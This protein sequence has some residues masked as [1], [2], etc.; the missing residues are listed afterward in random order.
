MPYGNGMG[1]KGLGPMSGKAM[2]SCA[3]YS[4]ESTEFA[5][6]MGRGRG[7]GRGFRSRGFGIGRMIGNRNFGAR[8][9]FGRPLSKE[10]EKDQ[11]KIRA[12]FLRSELE[13]LDKRLQ[14]DE[15]KN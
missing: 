15:T 13:I 6:G 2:G 10:E 5:A 9:G 3:V 4:Q 7:F 1:P 12:E 8:M 11:M 14:E